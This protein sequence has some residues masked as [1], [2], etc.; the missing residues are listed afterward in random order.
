[1]TDKAVEKIMKLGYV[2]PLMLSLEISKELGKKKCPYTVMFNWL[3]LE[4]AIKLTIKEG[5]KEGIQAFA[6]KVE[7]KDEANPAHGCLIIRR[8][9]WK[10]LLKKEGLV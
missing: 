2:M 10:A 6:K 3:Q 5:K 1:M 9:R 7:K 4:K 8:G